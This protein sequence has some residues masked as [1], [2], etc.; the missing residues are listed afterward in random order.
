MQMN[1]VFVNYSSK[2]FSVSE[3]L[4]EI[5]SA[6]YYYFKKNRASIRH[7]WKPLIPQVRY[8]ILSLLQQ[9]FIITVFHV[10]IPP[11]Y[12]LFFCCYCIS[13]QG[14]VKFLILKYLLFF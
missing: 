2:I 12:I 6:G 5:K 3:P 10:K 1:P 8:I 4:A 11:N 13:S 7:I 14:T 9:L